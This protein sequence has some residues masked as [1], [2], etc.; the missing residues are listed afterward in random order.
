MYCI[1]SNSKYVIVN[2]YSPGRYLCSAIAE[3]QLSRASWK[4][5]ADLCVSV[6]IYYYHSTSVL[7]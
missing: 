3:T 7:W 4:R 2:M 5:F 6:H 1:D